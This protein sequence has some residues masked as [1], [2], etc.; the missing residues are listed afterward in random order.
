MKVTYERFSDYLEG[1]QLVEKV[2]PS[3][4]EAFIFINRIQDNIIVRRIWISE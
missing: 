4:K 2:F 3:K 1:W